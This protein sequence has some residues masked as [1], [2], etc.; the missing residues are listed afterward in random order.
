MQVFHFFK[1]QSI[2]TT[3]CLPRVLN[4][5]CVVIDSVK[6]LGDKLGALSTAPIQVNTG[7]LLAS[8]A[9]L[10]ILKCF[11][12]S[13]LDSLDTERA[14]ACFFTAIN[15]EKQ[16]SVE[17]NDAAAKAVVILSQLWN[18]TKAFRKADGSEYTALRIRSRLVLSPVLDAVW[19]WRD[20]FDPLARTMAPSQGDTTEGNTT[21]PIC[22]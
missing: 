10:R 9:L 1:N 6:D 8:V 4:T 5:A 19:W 20:E 2:L 14:K 18:S 17:S 11:A 16:M 22:C 15:L 7:T 12:S 13:G 3:K 21:I